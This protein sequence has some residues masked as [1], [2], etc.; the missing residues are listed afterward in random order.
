MNDAELLAIIAQAEREGWTELDLSG[1]DLERLPSEIGR[2]QSLEKLILGKYEGGVKGNRLTAIPQ[3]IFQLTNLKE[4]HIPLNEI[5]AI[6][7]AIAQLSNLTNLSLFRNQITAIPDVIASLANLTTLEISGN[8]ITAIPDAIAQLSNLTSLNLSG[9]QITAIP[10]AIAQLSNLTMLAIHTNQITVIPDAITQLSNLTGL[11]F[12]GNQITAIP[13]AITQLSNLTTL[14]FSSNQITA[15]PDAISNLANLTTLR[16]SNNQITAIPDAIANLTNLTELYLYNNQIT[17]IPDA[18]AQLS[19]LTL[20]DLRDNPLP[21][22][23]EILIGYKNPA[24]I[25]GYWQKLKQGERKPLNEAKVILIGHGAVGKTSL[26]RQLIDRN[27]K[28]D[29]TKTE[30]IDIRHWQI[31]AREETVKLRVWDFGGQEIMHATHQ[32]F[33]TERSLYL[34]VLNARKDE[35]NN[36]VEYWLKIVES[37]GKDA[38][39]LII[40]NKSDEHPLKLNRRHLQEKYP[41]IQ[42]FFETSCKTGLG[43]DDLRK[44]IAQQ[45]AAMDHV[46]NELPQQWFRLKEQIEQ[47]N[48]DHIP[49]TEY[50]RICNDQ[51]I[52]DRQERSDLLRLLHLLGIVLNFADD[53]T[54]PDTSVLNPEWVTGGVYRILNDNKLSTKDKGMLNWQDLPRIL[55]P[56]DKGDRDC[57]RETR[58]RKFILDMM[59]K[60]ELCFPL[61]SNS[62][63]PVYLIPELLDEEETDTGTW[64]NTLNLEYHYKILFSSVISRFIVNMHHCIS[65]RTYWR[66]GVILEFSEGN[67]AQIKADLADAK[68]FIRIDGNPNT[69]RS[70]LAAIRNTFESIHHSIS[71]LEVDERVPLPDNPKVSI[72]YKHLLKLETKGETNYFPEGSDL[73]YNIRELLD[74]ISSIE[75]RRSRNDKT[76]SRGDTYNFYESTG[77]VITG[78][79]KTTGNNIGTQNNNLS[80]NFAPSQFNKAK[81]ATKTMKTILMLAANPKNSVSLRLQEEERDIKERLRL[82]GYGTEPIKTA[83]AVRPRDI[84]QAMLDFK[85]QIIHFSGHGADE[86]G[87]V[88]EDIDGQF[89]LI[90]GEDLADLFDLF[91]DRIECV[92]L[93]ACYSETQAEAIRQKIQYVIG[94]N[95]AIGDRAA[96]EFAVGFY[97]AIGAGEPYEF[98]FKLGCNAIRL[99]G[100]KEYTTPQLLKK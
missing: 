45:I 93:N 72:S 32:F 65:K 33:L 61:D 60:F 56:K 85:P 67:R 48:R 2:L 37:F 6:P 57:Y 76:E 77:Q 88:F 44:A 83:V 74:G 43:L 40:A 7:D 50:E 58:D 75:E 31:T 100:I 22:P 16:F 24:A 79:V 54:V 14:H 92:V 81:D 39:V 84:T 13:D 19:N 82:A 78:S 66:T 42:G 49:Y 68:I 53:P 8:Q 20:L 80:Q 3:E 34:L 55:T 11:T 59:Q 5:T 94:M 73:D 9:N 30:G 27:F 36:D 99:A 62:Q 21:I 91:S 96:I 89:K 29:E 98:A 71:A 95:Q 23:P 25:I 47:D 1:N 63:N 41:N 97:A 70:S 38:P 46:F 51:E 17:A 28:P 35:G 90:G 64:E 18:I 69:R 10:D 15:I 87:L 86:D 26:V 12:S 4:L 52:S